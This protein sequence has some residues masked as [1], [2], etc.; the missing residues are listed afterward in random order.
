MQSKVWPSLS[1]ICACLYDMKHISHS[2]ACN[3]MCAEDVH[4]DSDT[5]TFA[6][7]QI[8][9]LAAAAASLTTQTEMGAMRA[10]AA[11]TNT[12][13]C[14]QAER[15][16]T[17]TQQSVERELGLELAASETGAGSAEGL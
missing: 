17:P 7:T 8:H 6:D 14:H 1:M 5:D 4:I 13:S 11:V 16:E 9:S 15:I 12:T 10:G 2:R 3:F